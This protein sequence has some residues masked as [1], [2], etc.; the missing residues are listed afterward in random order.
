MVL[1]D[2]TWAAAMR[3]TLA[4]D[5]VWLAGCLAQAGLDIVPGSL[6]FRLVTGSHQNVAG[7]ANS[8]QS[9]GIAVRVFEEAYGIGS[10]AVRISAP[11]RQER[12]RLSAALAELGAIVH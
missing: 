3:E 9:D 2:R 11:H 1:A 10:S 6:H 5:A 12:W 4:S 8:L 7:F